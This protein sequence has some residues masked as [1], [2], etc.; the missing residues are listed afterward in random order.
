MLQLP[1][2]VLSK[3]LASL[4]S[5]M[6]GC[7]KDCLCDSHSIQNC[8]RSAASL[9]ASNA[10]LFQTMPQCGDLIP[11]SVPLT[12]SHPLPGAGPVLLTL[13]SFPP[14]SFILPN[15][16]WVCVCFSGNQVLV[17]TLRWCSVISSVSE[18]VFVMYPWR[19]V[20]PRSTYSSAILFSL[21]PHLQTQPH[22]GVTASTYEFVEG[23]KQS[24]HNNH[25]NNA[26]VI[27]NQEI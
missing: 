6:C 25:E 14:P 10:S 5:V 19:E 8:H 13:I 20:Y 21:F 17:P 2:T 18:S 27:L 16:A 9:S 7:D 22:H 11:A 15:F 3:G 26:V 12:H 24:V 1:A 4:S 23:H